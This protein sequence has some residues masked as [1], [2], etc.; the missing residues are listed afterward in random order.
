MVGLAEHIKRGFKP[1]EVEEFIDY[2]YHRP[3]A[4]LMV[5]LLL[6]LPFTPNQ[7]TIASGVVG[8]LAGVAIGCAGAGAEYW[9]VIGGCLLLLSILLDCADGQLARLRGIVSPA[10]RILDGLVDFAAPTAVFIGQAVF[11]VS[12]GHR[13]WL[14]LLVGSLA[15]GSLLWHAGQFD[16]VKNR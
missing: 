16:S 13:L 9:A 10:G 3:L 7:I 4:G 6:P 2:Y 15:G 14:V 12:L 8:V 11:L 1:R 5:Q